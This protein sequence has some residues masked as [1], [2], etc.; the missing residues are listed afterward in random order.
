MSVVTRCL[1]VLCALCFLSLST[2]VF[3]EGGEEV[4]K[5]EERISTRID[6]A[7]FNLLE[8]RSR[9][10]EERLRE[11]E[12]RAVLSEPEL[13]VKQKEIWVCD[14]GHEY[15]NGRDGK[16]PLDGLPLIKSFTYQREKV[17]RRQTISEKIEEVLAGEAKKGVSI[18]IS[19]TATAQEALRLK[20]NSN[21]ADGDL[22]GVG[23][24]DVFL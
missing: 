22:F 11:L 14:N 23:S 24:M 10:L 8:E 16:C 19:G 18:G 4:S 17:Y 2:L 1:P 3:A 20:G 12:S 13:L 7:R 21:E 15:D 5:D 6:A 9:E